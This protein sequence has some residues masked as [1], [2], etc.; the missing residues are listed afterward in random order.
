MESK[1][2]KSFHFPYDA[3]SELNSKSGTS[4][5]R[6]VWFKQIATV[7]GISAEKALT[8]VDAYP[9]PFSLLSALR[10]LSSMEERLALLKKLN[11]PIQRRNLGENVLRRLINIL[12]LDRYPVET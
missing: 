6:D 2:G 5:L 3:F 4:T 9:T 1:H 11:G 12:C 8:I 7:R 10:Q